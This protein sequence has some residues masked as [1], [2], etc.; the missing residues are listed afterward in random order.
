MN[1]IEK[2]WQ[3]PRGKRSSTLHMQ[4]LIDARIQNRS[5]LGMPP[6]ERNLTAPMQLPQGVPRHIVLVASSWIMVSLVL[7]CYITC[8]KICYT[9]CYM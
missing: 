2:Y 9:I 3:N 6:S 7:L 8:Y 4:P 5:E 1:L